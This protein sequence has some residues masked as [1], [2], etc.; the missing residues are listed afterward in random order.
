[1]SANAISNI[2]I[3]FGTDTS[4]VRTGIKSLQSDLGG[5]TGT[6]SRIAGVWA[7]VMAGRGIAGWISGSVKLAA[8]MESLKADFEVLTGSV[9][10]ANKMIAGLRD[11]DVKSPF[12]FEQ[13]SD[14]SR[15]LLAFN[16]DLEKVVPVMTQLAAI[17][18]ND[19]DK[20]MRLANVFGQTVAAGKLVG[21]NLRQMTE[22]GFNPLQEIARLTGE[23]MGDLIKKME[24]GGISLR[25]VEL[26]FE[27]ATAA[28][29]R[30]HGRLEKLSET[31][32]GRW[33]K[34]T[35]EIRLLRIE[36]GEFLMPTMRRFVN[37][38]KETIDWLR[39]WDASQLKVSASVMTFGITLVGALAILSR[40][41]AIIKAIVGALKAMASAQVITQA[42]SGPKGWAIL[43]TS[44][45][46]AGVA[47]GLVL[48]AFKDLEKQIDDTAKSAEDL[49]AEA[50]AIGD[51]LPEEVLRLKAEME[52]QLGINQGAEDAMKGLAKSM[53]DLKPAAFLKGTSEA[54]SA[55]N[56]ARVDTMKPL[57]PAVKDLGAK[58]AIGNVLLRDIRDR[59][60]PIQAAPI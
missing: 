33:N 18:G 29:G 5:L 57:L 58:L 7:G 3:R 4:G 43:A 23:D 39:S 15:L 42:L 2:A 37:L 50:E 6:L 13:L 48:D 45:V 51:K 34:L 14:A 30:F 60:D 16:T 53:R 54:I 19:S 41:P 26:A 38:A 22:A 11:L 17:A 20:L 36:I 47:T 31:M 44:M 56:R 35:N 25:L 40:M 21:Q 24:D 12:G 28:G 59:L 32:E 49:G 9:A 1:M 46:A 52:L 27:S 10:G 8:S 55:E